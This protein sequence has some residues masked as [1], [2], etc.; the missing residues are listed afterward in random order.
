M[1]NVIQGQL[2][3]KGYRYGTD[4]VPYPADSTSVLKPSATEVMLLSN[5]LTLSTGLLM[6]YE[7]NV[8][9]YLNSISTGVSDTVFD[10]HAYHYTCPGTL[11]V[12]VGYSQGAMVMHQAENYLKNHHYSAYGKLAG[13]VLLGDGNRIP[14]TRAREFGTSAASAE[15]IQ[16][17]L[18]PLSSHPDVP[19]P[20][21]TA[22]ICNANDIVCN[23]G[24]SQVLH[25]PSS[26]KVHTSYAYDCTKTACRYEPVLTTAA[27]WVG[28]KVIARL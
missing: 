19:L 14:R 4:S 6:Y 20:G 27:K 24:I 13:T 11:L 3:A 25:F 1:V 22:N 17:Y 26:A 18:T 8:K 16:T 28:G 10:A 9:K 23:F 12:L 7:D 2:H 21:T 5:P 15:G